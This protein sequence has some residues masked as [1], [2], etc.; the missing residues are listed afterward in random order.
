[1]SD[2][3]VRLFRLTGYDLARFERNIVKTDGCWTW[4]AKAYLYPR[5]RLGGRSGWHVSVARQAYFQ[6]KAP[7][8]DH[9]EIDHLCRNPRCVN[10][11]HLDAVTHRENLRRGNTSTARR[12]A[13]SACKNGHPA[14]QM[15]LYRGKRVCRACARQRVEAW[16]ARQ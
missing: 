14:E 15:R 16:K 6:Y 4:G 7:L 1:M 5:F 13:F 9:L 10:P 12:D 2:D 11:A 8:P 3:R